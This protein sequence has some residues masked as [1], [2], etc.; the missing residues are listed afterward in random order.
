[1]IAHIAI[2]QPSRK[3]RLLQTKENLGSRTPAYDD[4]DIPA[5]DFAYAT[6][7]ANEF[8]KNPIRKSGLAWHWYIVAVFLLF[9][10]FDDLFR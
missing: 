4:T 1:M 3:N 10:M 2:K 6:F 5:H 9:S 8:G 7:I